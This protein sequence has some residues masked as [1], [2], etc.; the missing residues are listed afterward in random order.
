MTFFLKR[1]VS[2]QLDITRGIL[3]S[4]VQWALRFPFVCCLALKSRHNFDVIRDISDKPSR[5]LSSFSG[6]AA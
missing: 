6:L 3:P 1:T 5:F 2:A 4:L